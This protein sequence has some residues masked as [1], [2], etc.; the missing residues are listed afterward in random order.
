MAKEEKSLSVVSFSLTDG[1]GNVVPAVALVAAPG[2][3]LR[4][5]EPWQRKLARDL[6]WHYRP[7]YVAVEDG[8]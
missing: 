6:E 4:L 8:E 3:A 5:D 1:S 2:E 7:P